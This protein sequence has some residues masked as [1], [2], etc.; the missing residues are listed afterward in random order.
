MPLPFLKLIVSLLFVKI[1]M[2]FYK[3]IASVLIL[4]VLLDGF[5][6]E[7]QNPTIYDVVKWICIVIMII[8]LL[9][10]ERRNNEK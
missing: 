5:D 4:L 7:F 6:G 3:I 1:N 8:C 2:K 9:I 10:T